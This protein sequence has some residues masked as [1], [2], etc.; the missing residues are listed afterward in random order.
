MR[1]CYGTPRITYV[2]TGR[3]GSVLNKTCTPSLCYLFVYIYLFCLFIHISRFEPRN[4]KIY[5]ST[6]LL[7]TFLQQN[8]EMYIV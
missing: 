3:V 7:L 2:F 6:R 5:P 4:G 1:V 8:N